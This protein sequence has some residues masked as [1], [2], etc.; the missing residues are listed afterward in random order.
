MY[1]FSLNQFIQSTR[2]VLCTAL[3]SS[4]ETEKCKLWLLFSQAER[5]RSYFFLFFLFCYYSFSFL[6]HHNIFRLVRGF[7]LVS[8]SY[9]LHLQKC[10]HIYGKDFRSQK[11]ARNKIKSFSWCF[12]CTE[13]VET[14]M[15]P[16][17]MIVRSM[18]HFWALSTT[19]P[20]PRIHSKPHIV[21][22]PTA[23]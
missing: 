18:I 6:L 16:V 2:R 14:M 21:L 7:P 22:V 3:K 12:P 20:L 15:V 13:A 23:I 8:P 19:I 9:N 1:S 10:L 5:Y 4:M 11:T 17:I